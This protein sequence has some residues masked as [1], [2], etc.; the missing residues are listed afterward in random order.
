M[1]YSPIASLSISCCLLICET[2]DFLIGLLIAGSGT[3][4]SV[5]FF[6]YTGFADIFLVGC[7]FCTPEDFPA[8]PFFSRYLMLLSTSYIMVAILDPILALCAP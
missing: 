7:F 2:L 3:D 6:D 5:C 1:D 8:W 4:V